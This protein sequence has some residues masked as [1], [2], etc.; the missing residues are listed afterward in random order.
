MSTPLCPYFGKCGGCSAQHLDYTIQLEN[1]KKLVKTALSVTEI[2][3]FSDQEYFY[4]NRMDF[5]F[6]P[7]GIGLREKGRSNKIVNVEQCV[8]ADNRIN[9]LLQ[10]AKAFYAGLSKELSSHFHSVMLRAPRHNSGIVFVLKEGS[11]SILE[12]LE[13]IKTFATI[14]T[15]QNVAVCYTSSE[16]EEEVTQNVVLIKG[17][18]HLTE[19][20]MRKEFEYPI[21]GFFQNNSH[22]AEKM[23][24]YSRT[25]LETYTTQ[26]A[27][28]LDLYGGVG[29][30]GIVNADLFRSVTIVENSAPAIAAAQQNI[31]KNG[32]KNA[33]AHVL[34]AK[35]LRK[36]NLG[37]P[38]FVITDPPRTGMDVK[39][40][41][42]LN[43]LQP[44]VILYV[45][46]NVQQLAKEIHK[47]KNYEIKSVALFDL[48]PQ[49]PHGEVVVEL[50]R[51]E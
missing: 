51:K 15:A 11:A 38:L 17:S 13:T 23:L 32:I 44:K 1:K 14:T 43:T 26:K 10:E 22:L 47:F 39:V 8:I 41:Q 45:S 31:L 36:V 20:F 48:F 2:T 42:Y 16:D 27:H 30:F 9:V 28:L 46:C 50:K 6:Y 25:V 3:A 19:Q 21:T 35:Q 4:R 34:D 7:R 37:T 29:T 40:I 5:W 18:L 24:E 33:T 49:T 12:V